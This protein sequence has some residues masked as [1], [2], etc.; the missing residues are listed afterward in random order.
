MATFEVFDELMEI[1]G[2]T[3]LHKRMRFWFVQEI[4]KEEGLLKFLRD[5]CDDL[6]R[7]NA[8][9]RVLIREMEGSGEHGGGYDAKRYT[10]TYEAYEQFQA[11][12]NQEAEGSGSGIKRTRTY[13]SSDREEVNN[14]YSKTILATMTLLLNIQKRTLGEGSNNDLNVLYGSPL[15][16]D[17]L[18]DMAPEA[19]FVV[20]GRTYK[21]GYYLADGKGPIDIFKSSLG[22]WERDQLEVGD[23]LDKYGHKSLYAFNKGE[24]TRGVPIR[25]NPK[26]GRSVLTYKDGSVVSLD[27]DSKRLATERKGPIDI[28]TSSLGGWERDQLKVGD[29]LD[30]YGLKSLYAFN[31]SV[32][33]RGVPIRFNPKNGR[34]VLTYKDGSV[35]SLDGDPKLEV[36]DILDKYGLKSLYAFNKSEKTRGVPIRFNPKNGRSVLTYKDG[37]VVSLDGDPKVIF[38]FRD[39][40]LF[41][42]KGPIDIF[43]SSL[44]GWER[45]QLEVGDILDKYGLKSLYAFN[46]SEKTRGVPIRFNLKNGRSVL[47]YKDGYVVSLDGDPKN[48]NVPFESFAL[49]SLKRFDGVIPQCVGNITF[50]MMDLGNNS[51]QGTIPNVFEEFIQLEGLILNGNQ[52][53]GG[54]PS[55][56]SKCEFLGVLDLGNNHLNGTFPGWLGE[57]R[58]LQV[59]ILK[60]NN[61]HGNIQPSFAVKFPFPCLRVLDLSHNGFVGQLPTK[62]FQN[63]DSMKNFESSKR[64]GK[65]KACYAME[66]PCTLE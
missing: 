2:S 45:D 35:V 14:A 25:F 11:M 20:N 43:T 56:L 48:I 30:K 57:L 63:F 54:V 62:Y 44:G 36:G 12:T 24:K 31:K 64:K 53:E 28:F 16:D 4:A 17:V 21:Q 7:K 65:D 26:N 13:I 52:L 60:S 58:F 29:I 1:T 10:R 41:T 27:G 61:F 23:I 39:N 59:L 8:R 51:F 37:S 18:A 47:T 9:R 55:S 46:K 42:C 49:P 22:G 5:R 34:S 50:T 38:F 33:T 32:K 40:C 3:E 19:P 66:S 15:F 6:R